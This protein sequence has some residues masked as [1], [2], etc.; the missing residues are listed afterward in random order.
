MKQTGHKAGLTGYVETL[1]QVKAPR[2]LLE[3]QRCYAMIPKRCRT[4][5]AQRW[6]VV[7]LALRKL[8]GWTCEAKLS[9]I[10]TVPRLSIGL[11]LG[12]QG[13]LLFLLLT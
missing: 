5:V 11:G 4:E 13:F 1:A 9:R 8:L 6:H 10:N 2:G 7:H 3:Q 12:I